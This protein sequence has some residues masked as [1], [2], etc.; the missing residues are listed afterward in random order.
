[1]AFAFASTRFLYLLG[2]IRETVE[3]GAFGIRERHGD[4]A[5]H[6]DRFEL[7]LLGLGVVRVFLFGPNDGLSE[8]SIVQCRQRH[9]RVRPR[10]RVSRCLASVSG[11]R[12]R[13][14]EQPLLEQHVDEIRPELVSGPFDAL[15]SSFR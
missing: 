4:F 15:R 3:H 10:S 5:G 8:Y 12:H 11:E 1:M 13:R 9:D 14:R 7:G 2:P 6:F